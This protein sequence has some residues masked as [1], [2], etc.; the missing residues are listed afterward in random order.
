MTTATHERRRNQY[1]ANCCICG[2][3]VPA[4]AGWLYADTKARPR[5]N[6]GGSLYS[7]FPKKVKC[8]RCHSENLTNK[9]QAQNLDN[10]QPAPPRPWS[11]PQVRKWTLETET[12]ATTAVKKGTGWSEERY[13]AGLGGYE[14]EQI[15][16]VTVFMTVGAER[17]QLAGSDAITN[18]QQ[19][20]PYW[21]LEEKGIG[22]KPF[23]PAAWEAL[24]VK[25][26]E[27]VDNAKK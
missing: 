4:E 3:H 23:S 21:T 5:L 19:H 13:R 7:R 10:P 26:R 14:H 9:F 18:Q 17:V 15:T 27:A 2:H 6:R 11:A 24:K 20:G 25:V 8:D 12:E 22:G 1:P 16:L